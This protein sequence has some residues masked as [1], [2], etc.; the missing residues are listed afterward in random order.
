M[1]VLEVIA[2]V[3]VVIVTTTTDR[4]SHLIL[5]NAVVQG[6]ADDDVGDEPGQR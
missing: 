4:R 1:M 5:T 3:V 2:V 6:E